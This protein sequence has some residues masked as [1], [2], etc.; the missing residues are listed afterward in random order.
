MKHQRHHIQEEHEIEEEEIVPALVTDD[1][2]ADDEGST[3]EAIVLDEE[4]GD[5]ECE[6]EEGDD[7][8]FAFGDPLAPYLL[9]SE[10]ESIPDVLKGILES[11]N[12]L[13]DVLEKQSRILFKISKK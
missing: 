10:G 9:T 1:D 11:L 7:E 5:D 13:T 12:A 8:E 3:D 4:E 6:E 2:D